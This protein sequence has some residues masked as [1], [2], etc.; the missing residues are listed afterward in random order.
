MT[1]RVLSAIEKRELTLPGRTRPQSASAGIACF[2]KEAAG[3][4]ELVRLAHEALAKAVSLGG[5]RVEVAR[6]DHERAAR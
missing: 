5:N 1:N 3:P 4:E 6:R 2:T